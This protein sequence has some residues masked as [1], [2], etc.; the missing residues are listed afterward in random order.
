MVCER[1]LTLH[2]AEPVMAYLG[3]AGANL[4]A[5]TVKTSTANGST[6]TG[7]QATVGEPGTST[8]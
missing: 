3:G 1:D 4:G 5:M 6:R 2:T 8:R 7:T